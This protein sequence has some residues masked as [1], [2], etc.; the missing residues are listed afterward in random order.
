MRS[1]GAVSAEVRIDRDLGAT[2]LTNPTPAAV[3]DRPQILAAPRIVSRRE[4]GRM[5]AVDI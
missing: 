3:L 5:S 2:R 1:F 4:T